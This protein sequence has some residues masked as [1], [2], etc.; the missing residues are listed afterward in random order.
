MLLLLLV[1]WTL[2]VQADIVCNGSGEYL[3][4]TATMGDV[5]SNSTG[6]WLV[7]YRP[8][9]TAEFGTQCDEGEHIFGQA[10]YALGL[11]RHGSL[12]GVH[13]V[14]GFN[15]D[16][17]GDVVSA[18]QTT[19][20]WTQIAFVHTGGTILL[21]KEGVSLAST[22]S[23]NTEFV[24]SIL[25]LCKNNNAYSFSFGG[26]IGQAQT[27]ATALSADVIA[28]LGKSQLHHVAPVAPSGSWSLSS[29]ADGVSCNAQTF[30]DA[31][32]NARTLTASGT[33]GQASS[34]MGWP[35]GVE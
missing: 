24:S 30:L 23:G 15:F 20:T 14:C 4:T 2:P 28:A 25:R 32:G 35:W 33:I 27:F 10:D 9:G 19:D 13:S 7:T 11:Y 18:P 17:N 1:L 3:E 34:F 8:T 21:Y 31:S 26:V 12:G 22:A 16:G 6:T 29:C 5:M